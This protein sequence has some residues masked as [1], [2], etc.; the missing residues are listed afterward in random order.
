MVKT[1]TAYLGGGCFWCT[2]ALFETVPG[3]INVV[4]GYAGGHV[5]NPSYDEVSHTQTGHAEVIQIEFDPDIVSYRDLLEIFFEIHDPTTLNRQGADVGE[6][7]RSI[8]LF[9]D[10][11]QKGTAESV[12]ASLEEAH[13][14][15][16]FMVS[17]VTYLMVSR[18]INKSKYL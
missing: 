16:I 6:Q 1:Q 18:N 2:E 8:I 3:V 12:I 15:G 17:R 4:S 13:M 9:T 10:A 14:I 7:Y 11:E 5:E